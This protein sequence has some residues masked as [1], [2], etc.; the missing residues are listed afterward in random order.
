MLPRAVY[1]LH[2][3]KVCFVTCFPIT[4]KSCFPCCFE[5]ARLFGSHPGPSQ[6]IVL[7][8]NRRST[9]ILSFTCPHFLMALG[10]WK[11]AAA[12]PGRGTWF[13][14]A[15]LRYPSFLL[16]FLPPKH[17][18]LLYPESSCQLRALSR[19]EKNLGPRASS[20]PWHWRM[21]VKEDQGGR[22]LSIPGTEATG[23]A[24]CATQEL[25][26]SRQE[27]DAAMLRH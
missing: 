21:M 18:C 22:S 19:K 13:W 3:K 11:A 5:C 7:A 16:P 20:C 1:C 14:G 25:A 8:V 23:V 17:S 2:G 4:G 24:T 6:W 12:E 26:L 27:A 9:W 10:L 15:P